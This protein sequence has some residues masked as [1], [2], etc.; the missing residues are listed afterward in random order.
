MTPKEE[1]L[2]LASHHLPSVTLKYVR[3]SEQDRGDI[4]GGAIDRIK[5]SKVG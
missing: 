5:M 1:A 2:E 4:W 3:P